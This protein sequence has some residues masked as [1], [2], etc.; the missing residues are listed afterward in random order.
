MIYGEMEFLGIIDIPRINTMFYIDTSR[1]DQWKVTLYDDNLEIQTSCSV[2]SINFKD[3]LIVDRP[4][5]QAIVSKIQNSSRHGSVMAIDYKKNATFGTGE[6]VNSMMLAG[7]KSDISNLKY[8]LMSLLGLKADPL[9]GEMK[10]QEIHLLF[11]LASGV[12]SSD[13]LLPIFDGDEELIRRTFVSLKTKKLVDEYASITPQGAEL[14]ERMKELQVDPLIE[15]LGPKDARLLFLLASGV[16][17]KEMLLPIFDGDEELISKIYTS[18][19]AKKLV[20]EYANITPHG[21]EIIAKMKGIDKKKLGSSAQREFEKLSTTWNYLDTMAAGSEDLIRIIWKCGD[22]SLCGNLV[23]TEIKRF[24][25]S[26]NIRQIKIENPENTHYIDII[27]N[28]TDDSKMLM[29]SRDYSTLIALYGML[30]R[31]EDAQIRILFC[32]Y[33]GYTMEPDILKILNIPRSHYERHF[34]ILVSSSLVDM[35]SKELTN[36]GVKLISRKIIGDV[37]VLFEWNSSDLKDENF[38]RM[39]DSKKACAKKKVLDILQS[40]YDKRNNPEAEA[41]VSR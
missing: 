35:D 12:N 41:R 19:K 36:A 2:L 37:S 5:P 33:L 18:L 11:L 29:R 28:A 23:V 13:M 39:E 15:N 17:S 26:S 7:K 24:I 34:A 27:V 38:K 4:L 30:N 21:A 22:S 1:W 25:S 40:K 8:M 16:K 14:I 10:P 20:D 6:V 9:I 31:E 32:F 3:I